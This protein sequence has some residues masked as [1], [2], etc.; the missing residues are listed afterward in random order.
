MD[1]DNGRCGIIKKRRWIRYLLFTG[2]PMKTAQGRDD[3]WEVRMRKIYLRRHWTLEAAKRILRD[4]RWEVMIRKI[5]LRRH[6]TI[7][8]AKKILTLPVSASAAMT[9]ETSLSLSLSVTFTTVCVWS[10]HRNIFFWKT[11]MQ[12]CGSMTFW[13][14]D[15]NPN[16]DPRIHASD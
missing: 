15:P 13:C 14:V 12:C 8:A 3:R 6:W 4:D 11:A 10:W 1:I 2:F 5:Y 9:S 7:E 16:P